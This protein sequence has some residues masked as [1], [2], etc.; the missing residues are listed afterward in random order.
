MSCHNGLMAANQPGWYKD[1]WGL[2]SVRWW[3]GFQWTPHTSTTPASMGTAY[4]GDIAAAHS[5][6]VRMSKWARIAIFV[7]AAY[8][9]LEAV[10]EMF[11]GGMLRSVFHQMQVN[12]Q[13]G[14]NTAPNMTSFGGSFALSAITGLLE[15]AMIPLAVF[16]LIWQYNAAKV[17][18]G[19]GYPSRLSPGLGVGS[20]FIPI[21]SLWFPHWALSDLLPPD[22]PYRRKAVAAWWAYVLNPVLLLATVLFSLD[23]VGAA[24]IPLAASACLIVVAVK[25][26][27]E[28][29]DAVQA[30]H[31]DKLSALTSPAPAHN[32]YNPWNSY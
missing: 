17:A 12:A 10:S 15:L 23:S 7:F 14:T 13:D 31:R 9:L 26:G 22:H 3:D 16:F 21:V 5:T 28:C 27:S 32:Q 4:T 6:A 20:W 29:F 2:A 30:D 18:R 1:P 11:A 25:L 19:L 24:L 8:L